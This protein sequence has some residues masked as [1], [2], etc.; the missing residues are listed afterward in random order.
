MITTSCNKDE[1]VILSDD[2]FITLVKLTSGDFS[3][4]FKIKDKK[5]SGVVPYTVNDLE[6]ALAITISDKATITPDPSTISS[7][8]DPI[9]FTV[10]AENGEKSNYVIDIKREL[11]PEKAVTSFQIKTSFFETNVDIDQESGIIKKRVLPKIS[12]TS[13]TPMITISDKATISP[14]PKTIS[15]YTN[16]V[17]F[18]VTAENGES[19]EYKVDLQLMDK[20]FSVQCDIRN[21]SKW[22]GGDDR[23]VPEYPEIGP[24][25]VG[26]G[27][28]IKVKKDTY[29]IKFGFFLTDPF[30]S[31]QTGALYSKNL[32]L[33]LDIRNVDG[34]IEKTLK[35]NVSG[36]FNGGWIDFD[37][38]SAN[39]F[40]K[41][42]E[43][44]N[45]TWYLV[46]GEELGISSGTSGNNN[47]DSGL[48]GATGWSGTSKEKLKTSLED[49]DVWYDHP[50]HFN[51]RLEGKQ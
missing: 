48:C 21:A 14:D 27:Q 11:S 40:L 22:F 43:S 32:E 31:S 37:L 46:K 29:P 10:T 15:D 50:W 45:F 28:T 36:P 4:D 8:K 35:K 13:L 7:I 12:L 9:N 30:R 24:R 18:T 39:V 42:G 44:Y 26:T 3:K 41:G 49:W 33:R 47:V 38:S 5:V 16:P 2:N 51:F 6:V 34:V 20:D 19:K 1:E 23:V 17:V 25:N